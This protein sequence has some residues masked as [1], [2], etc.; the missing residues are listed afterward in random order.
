MHGIHYRKL[1]PEIFRLVVSQARA[2]RLAVINMKDVKG[3]ASFLA[4][5]SF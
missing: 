5:N 4:P 1:L 2:L 3:A